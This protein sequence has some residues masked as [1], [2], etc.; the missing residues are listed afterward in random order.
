MF[1]ALN[2]VLIVFMITCAVA[3]VRVR[4]LVSAVFMISAFAFFV[5]ILW[6]MLGAADVSFT[7]AMVGVGASTIFY[8][9]ALFRTDHY[10]ENPSF[11]YKPV[12]A[13]LVVAALAGLFIWGSRDL[14]WFGDAGSV[15]NT[16]LSPVYL[17][18]AVHDAGT[19][20]VVTAVLADYRGFDTLLETAVVF[21]AGIACILI[22][23]KNDD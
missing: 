6:S 5:A 10:A 11:N 18:E 16:Y 13:G 21:I 15:A 3:A 2:I 12:F 19:P 20:N 14:P 22:M 4:E 9:L 23:R 7:E 8:L 17:Q 1:E